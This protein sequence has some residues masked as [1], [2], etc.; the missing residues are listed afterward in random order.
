MENM[1]A[2]MLTLK[3]QAAAARGYKGHLTKVAKRVERAKDHLN[4][5]TFQEAKACNDSLDR[6]IEIFNKALDKLETCISEMAV[7]LELG[8]SLANDIEKV[9]DRDAYIEKLG[10][11][12]VNID[13]SEEEIE[14]NSINIED[15][16]RHAIEVVAGLEEEKE[17]VLE[18]KFKANESFKKS[19][20]DKT[21]PVNDR[22]YRPHEDKK[23][24]LKDCVGLKP[25][26]ISIESSPED[27]ELWANSAR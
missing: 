17:K 11:M 19:I 26:I 13:K 2:Q 21:T 9:E 22:D 18:D 10:K 15:I 3:Q 24:D 8:M 25:A 16:Q 14:T 6:Q 1:D 12:K 7:S 4:R 20:L 27:V 5:A 23:K